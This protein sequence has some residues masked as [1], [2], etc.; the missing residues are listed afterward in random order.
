MKK[1]L[2]LLFALLSMTAVSCNDEFIEKELN[3][4]TQ[5]EEEGLI[6]KSYQVEFESATRAILDDN[7]PVWEIGEKLSVYDPIASKSRTF[8]VTEVKDNRATISGE[9][10]EGDF[11]FSAVY[12]ENCAGSWSSISDC[13]ITIPST[14]SI[15][16][17]REIDPGVLVSQ[18]YCETPSTSAII[19]HNK[20]ALLS[21]SITKEDIQSVKIELRQSESSSKSYT[22]T[23]TGG[24]MPTRQLLYIA[25]DAGD[26]AS[27]VKASCTT[28]CDVDY[29]KSSANKLSAVENG[30]IKLGDISNGIKHINYNITA[31]G[32]IGGLS[33]YLQKIGVTDDENLVKAITV[34]VQSKIDDYL[35]YNTENANYVCYT[36]KSLDPYGKPTTVSSYLI[37]PQKAVTNKRATK[38]IVIANHVSMINGEECPTKTTSYEAVTVFKNYAV[39]IPDYLG[40]G[41]SEQYAQAYTLLEGTSRS[42]FDSYDAAV[43]IL[44][45]LE[46]NIGSNVYNIG[47]S[48]GGYNAIANA[49]YLA[50]HPERGITLKGTYAGGAPTDLAMT[51]NKYLSGGYN[52]ATCYV[53]A[54]IIGFR[55]YGARNVSYSQIFTEPLLSN[56]QEWI[57]SKKYSVGGVIRNIGTDDMSK[58]FTPEF[59][60]KSNSAYNTLI[61]VTRDNSLTEGDWSPVSKSTI[62]LYHSKD[63]DMVPYENLTAIKNYLSGRENG[64]TI[65]YLNLDKDLLSF[66][67]KI[68]LGTIIT[69]AKGLGYDFNLDQISHLY[70]AG[71]FFYDLAAN[72]L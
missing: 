3:L 39:V 61:N 49:R 70:G 55:E 46:A 66:K 36:H 21:F 18:A 44:S 42:T 52:D 60:N 43:Q 68:L 57:I 11:A 19:F 34:L 14:Q 67:D 45:D 54:S 51:Y 4:S 12:P 32:T 26:Y 40:F 9:I 7:T 63:D 20:V 48:Q 33:D 53:L 13:S 29:E 6:T 17:G 71:F 41:A 65:K 31:T 50:K 47:Y 16:E 27:G 2:I 28:I 64:S 58:I 38:G 62:Y 59:Y 37:Y 35:P 15:P 56:Y 22:V 30:L 10:S 24:P 25:V 69:T 72:R 5:E 1:H 8:T 23:S